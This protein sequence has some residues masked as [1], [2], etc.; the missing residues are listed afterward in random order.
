MK[1]DRDVERI[2]RLL[3]RD[4]ASTLGADHE[5]IVDELAA[6]VFTLEIADRGEKLVGDVQQYFQDNFVD[7]TWPACPRHPNHPLDFRPDVWYCP[8]DG[9]TVAKLGELDSVA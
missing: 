4:I 6:I 3:R 2:M 1:K 5:A 8:R 9:Q 7:I